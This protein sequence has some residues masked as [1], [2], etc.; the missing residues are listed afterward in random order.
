MTAFS[1]QGRTEP[2]EEEALSNVLTHGRHLT[3][4]RDGSRA[5]SKELACS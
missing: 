2:K 1:T 5:R 4:G 3:H